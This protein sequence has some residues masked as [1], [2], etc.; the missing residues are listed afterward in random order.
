[1]A[2]VK[3]RIR[4]DTAANWASVDPVLALGE[5]G[6]ETDTRRVKYGDGATDWNDLDYAAPASLDYEE[7]AW[8]PIVAASSGALASYSATGSYTKI[9]RMVHASVSISITENGSGAASLTVSLPFLNGSGS[10]IGAGRE[11][12]V[13]GAMLQVVISPAGSI[14]RIFTYS[15]AY[16]AGTG[17]ILLVTFS[18]AI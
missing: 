17:F 3:F 6:L 12:A 15:N 2:V 13:T 10:W 16:P 1:M 9:G 14:A 18:Y 7:G 8:S 11:N 4:R 5:P